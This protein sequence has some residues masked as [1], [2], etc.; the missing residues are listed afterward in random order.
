[1]KK[2]VPVSTIMTRNPD[3]V[4]QGSKPSEVL[5]AF[6]KG[7][8]HHMPVVFGDKLVGLITSTDLLKITYDFGADARQSAAILDHT[9]SIDDI[10]VTDVRTPEELTRLRGSIEKLNGVTG[11]KFYELDRTKDNAIARF[12]V[13]YSGDSDKLLEAI[14]SI[15]EPGFVF[16]MNAGSRDRVTIRLKNQ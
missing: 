7:R 10:M 6:D 11:T 3:V 16:D 12:D 9:R 5:A 2:N 4:H 13:M 15:N 14:R 8:Y 1:M